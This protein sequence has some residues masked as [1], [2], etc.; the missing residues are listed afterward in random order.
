VNMLHM[1]KC[2]APMLMRTS[3]MMISGK[4]RIRA[5]GRRE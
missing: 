3:W 5:R 4:A 2:E 1:R